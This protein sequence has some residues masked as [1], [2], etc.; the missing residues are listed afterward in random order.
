MPIIPV[1]TKAW[2]SALKLADNRSVRGFDLRHRSRPAQ[3]SS[4]LLRW[5]EG[6]MNQAMLERYDNSASEAQRKVRSVRIP[7]TIVDRPAEFD[8]PTQFGIAGCPLGNPPRPLKNA[9]SISA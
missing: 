7:R 8:Q 6:G 1:N 5:R 2:A 3:P 4:H 9:P